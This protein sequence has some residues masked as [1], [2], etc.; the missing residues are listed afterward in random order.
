MSEKIVNFYTR[1]EQFIKR[2]LI[3]LYD[4]MVVWVAGVL[5]LLLRFDLS[6]SKI[7][8]NFIENMQGMLI[9]NMVVTIAIFTIN[10]LYTSLW[11]YAGVVEMQRIIL[12]T[13]ETTAI[14]M[15]ISFIKSRDNLGYFLPRTY[16]IL[17]FFH[18]IWFKTLFF[19]AF[20]GHTHGTWRF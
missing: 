18:Y 17:Y 4:L 8:V 2:A 15:F 13:I 11:A 12:A 14:E 6:F 9:V 3:I 19:L 1:Y 5:A 7:P 20:L 16:H 10:H